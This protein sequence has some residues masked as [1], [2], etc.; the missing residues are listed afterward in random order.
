MDNFVINISP[1]NFFPKILFSKRFY[2]NGPA[3]FGLK[4]PKLPDNFGDISLTNAIFRKYLRENCSSLLYLQLSF[5]YFVNL[6]FIPK[7]FSKV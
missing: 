6:C 4:Q 2:H 7:L 1:S 3:E 5:K